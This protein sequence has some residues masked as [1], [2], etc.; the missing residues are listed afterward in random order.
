MDIKKIMRQVLVCAVFLGLSSTAHAVATLSFG[1]TVDY[2]SG[3]LSV[4]G[5]LTGTQSIIPTPDLTSSFVGLSTT[6]VSETTVSGVTIGTF[7]GGTIL[8]SDSSGTLLTGDFSSAQMGGL[9]GSNQGS[10]TLVFSP[11][12]GSLFSYFSNPSDLFA[13][14]L[15]LTS[16]FGAGMFGSDFS[17]VGNGNIT[18]RTIPEPGVLSLL[19]VGLGLLGVSGW[20]RRRAAVTR[21]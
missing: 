6:F 13:L 18:S 8:V 12:G 19:V 15:N 11:T 5:Q 17:G 21:G 2:T 4:D 20:Q 3:L 10:L 7:G 16:N 1:G 14:T 9:D